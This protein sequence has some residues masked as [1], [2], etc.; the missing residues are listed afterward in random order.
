MRTRPSGLAAAQ[1]TRDS[2][3]RSACLAPHTAHRAQTTSQRFILIDT[4]E[5]PLAELRAA[6]NF[7]VV[8][9][10]EIKEL[11][12]RSARRAQRRARVG[13]SRR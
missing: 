13:S 1:R 9:Q 10:H 5:K 12:V 6:E 4:A 3:A 2:Q 8:V 11:G 7:D